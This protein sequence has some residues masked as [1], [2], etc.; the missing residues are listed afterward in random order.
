M[1]HP[2][3]GMCCANGRDACPVRDV[4]YVFKIRQE[5]AVRKTR[6]VKEIFSAENLLKVAAR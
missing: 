2:S 4:C 5:T 6:I 1:H 3:A